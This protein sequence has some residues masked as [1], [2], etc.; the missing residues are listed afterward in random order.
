M[1]YYGTE[2]GM[3]GADDPDDRKPMVWAD[4]DYAPEALGPFGK[5]PSADANQ[6]DSSLYQF[7]KSAIELRHNHECLRRGDIQFVHADDEAR[8]LGFVRRHE[9]DTLLVVL[10]RDEQPHDVKA[11]IPKLPD[12]QSAAW[13][14]RFVSYKEPGVALLSAGANSV[15]VHL[16]PLT[17]AVYERVV[18]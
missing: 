11:E 4:L 17:G 5:R 12:D 14:L 18:D 10:N 2:S 7:Y 3:W 9:N 16:P 13:T 8:T 1:V 6:F 15:T